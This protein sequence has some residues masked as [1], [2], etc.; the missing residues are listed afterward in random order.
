MDLLIQP[1]NRSHLS[2]ISKLFVDNID[3][4]L[5]ILED[6][7]REVADR[8]VS[9]W[10]IAGIT[11][12]PSG[13]YRVTITFSQR[14]QRPLPLLNDVPGYSGVR[15]HPGNTDKDT[16]GCLLPGLSCGANR[17]NNSRDA[18]DQ[19]FELIGNA[20]DAGEEVWIEVVR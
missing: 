18:F 14:F 4:G 15:I 2:T 16:E 13:R 11:A 1:L 10:K 8:P 20:I 5:Y 12:I 17:V 3:S 19:L 6:T 9:S 7:V